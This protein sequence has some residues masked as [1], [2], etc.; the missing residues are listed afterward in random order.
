M[1][2]L[3]DETVDL[4]VR[5]SSAARRCI[6]CEM[7]F[8]IT[9]DTDDQFLTFSQN[10][11]AELCILHWSTI[12]GSDSGESTHFKNVFSRPDV[13]TVSNSLSTVES[14]RDRF[15]I[16]MRN[17]YVAHRDDLTDVSLPDIEICKKQCGAIIGSIANLLDHSVKSGDKR[18]KVDTLYRYLINNGSERGIE[19]ECERAIRR[20]QYLSDS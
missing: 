3:D 17:K 7:Y 20:A 19:I 10:C 15:L 14:V 4:L 16:D 5:L 12:F 13:N 2:I 18:E 11:F 9:S 6:M 8:N 1:M